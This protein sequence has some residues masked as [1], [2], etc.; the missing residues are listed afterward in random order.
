M[1]VMFPYPEYI[2][3]QLIRTHD[4]FK[5][6]LHAVGGTDSCSGYRV[7]RIFNEAVDADLHLNLSQRPI[8]CGAQ[9]EKRRPPARVMERI[10]VY[11]PYFS[12]TRGANTSAK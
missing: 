4:L 5:L 1:A 10:G 12:L 11:V 2:Q 8:Y 6:I 3:A 7:W 9:N